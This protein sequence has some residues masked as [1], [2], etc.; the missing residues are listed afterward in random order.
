MRTL[1]TIILLFFVTLTLTGCGSGNVPL[2]GKVI[3]E[4]GTLLTHGI[5]VFDDGT[6]IARATIQPDGTFTAGYDKQNNGLPKGQYRVYIIGTEEMLPNPEEVY[7]PPMRP[8]MNPKYSKKETSGLA[9][10]VDGSSKTFD[11]HVE[12]AKP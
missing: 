7:P 6:H 2:S 3:L 4:D 5:I 8:L 9:V 11:I 1:I 12:N 10:N